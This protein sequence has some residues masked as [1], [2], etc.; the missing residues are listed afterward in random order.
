MIPKCGLLLI[1]NT[2][3]R[4]CPFNDLITKLKVP[5]TNVFDYYLDGEC[6]LPKTAKIRVD[7]I[8]NTT[9][10]VV[11]RTISA[12]N[13]QYI[14]FTIFNWSCANCAT[15]FSKIILALRHKIVL[16]LDT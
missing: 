4:N 2:I 16:I 13:H 1:L 15:P 9:K 6:S 3:S 12:T 7:C 11:S 5:L 8:D 10:K 14:T